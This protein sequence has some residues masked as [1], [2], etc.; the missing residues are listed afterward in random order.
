M[1]T[2]YNAHIVDFTYR[3][4]WTT[5]KGN[6][7]VYD[8]YTGVEANNP[9]GSTENLKTETYKDGNDEIIFIVTYSYNAADNV[10]SEVCS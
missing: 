10:I 9:S 8:Y 6:S 1:E 7:I 4:S 5:I 2:K 3:S